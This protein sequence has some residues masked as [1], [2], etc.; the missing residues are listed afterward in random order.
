MS[1]YT[2]PALNAVD[3]ALTSH[4]PADLTPA[5]QALAAY[6][7]PALSAVDFAL[8]AYTQPTYPDVGWEL[9]PTAGTVNYTLVCAAGS[10]A[11]S[12]VAANLTVAR[13]LSLDAGAYSYTGQAASLT[14][15][16]RLALDAGAYTYTGQAA[17]LGLER[18]LALDTGSY[19]YTGQDATLDYVA[20]TV[21]P[22]VTPPVSTTVSGGRKQYKWGIPY[23]R[24]QEKRKV[25]ALEKK[26]EVA[27]AKVAKVEQTIQATTKKL[28][29]AEDDRASTRALE[30]LTLR[31][32][33]LHAKAEKIT[34][35][36]A[37]LRMELAD[38]EAKRAA[39]ED[40]EIIIL[41]MTRAIH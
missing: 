35:Q 28:H 3:F 38:L 22:P 23:I 13:K 12:G 17:S 6:T 2:P 32:D 8:A 21:T 20:G 1:A 24:P 29:K 14:V 34:E 25:A 27:V 26:L 33:A 11:Y 30:L 40:E 39:F 31:S 19:A 7:P 10:Y 36:I 4:T 18:K 9:L 37:S 41:M 15:A 5:G 16:R